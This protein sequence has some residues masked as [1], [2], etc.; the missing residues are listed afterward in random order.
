MKIGMLILTKDTRYL[1]LGY[2]T[3]IK[4]IKSGILINSIELGLNQG[5]QYT[6]SS[7]LFAKTLT[8]IKTFS[9][10]KLKSKEIILVNKNCLVTVGILISN[11]ILPKKYKK[12]SFFRYKG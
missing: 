9:L 10:I 8:P 4:N 2:T 1:N 7:G 11:N 12:A 6:R 5:S 3:L